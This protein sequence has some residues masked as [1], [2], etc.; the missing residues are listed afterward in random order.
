MQHTLS[1]FLF[2]FARKSA[3]RSPS[4]AWFCPSVSQLRGLSGDAFGGKLSQKFRFTIS[5]PSLSHIPT[6]SS[7]T[8]QP[9]QQETRDIEE[10]DAIW[11]CCMIDLCLAAFALWKV[12]KHDA[13]LLR[14]D[15]WSHG[16]NAPQTST[17]EQVY[18]DL[19][20]P[21]FG[22]LSCFG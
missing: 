6:P 2:A 10:M 17:W 1:L 12:N 22:C 18:R 19:K 9:Q 16:S 15:L 20:T 11:V 3:K 7:Q 8:P 5:L 4:Q 13:Q 14:L 21:L